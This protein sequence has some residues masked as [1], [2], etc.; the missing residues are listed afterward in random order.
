MRRYLIIAF[1][2]QTQGT[3][4]SA[5]DFDLAVL[6]HHPLTLDDKYSLTNELALKLKVSEDKID[7]IDLWDAPPLLQ[8]QIATK[9]QLIEGS[10]FDFLRF[11]VL[12]WKRYQ[13]T[14]KFRRAREKSLANTYAK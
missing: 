6:S 3:S 1:G 13:D 11:K 9:G 8:Y 2:S 10:D 7:L 5:S 12:A 4:S 14:A